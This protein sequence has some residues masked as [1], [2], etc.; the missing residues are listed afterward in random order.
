MRKLLRWLGYGVAA[1]VGLLLVGAAWIW[2]ASSREINRAYA[3]APERLVRPTA[4]QLADAERQARILGCFSCHGEGLAGRMMFSAPGVAEI[5]SP[6]LT[7]VA[8]DASDEQLA[9]A[10]RQG[11]GVDGEP[12]FVMPSAMYSRLSDGEVAALVALIR[13]QPRRGGATPQPWLGP[14]GRFGVATGRLRSAP[15]MLEE[16][17]IREPFDVGPEHAAGRRLAAIA[18]SECH[19]A[20][21]GGGQPS[22][23]I[24]APD[25]ALA[26]AYDPEQ[27]RTLMRTGRAPHG[28]DLG[29]MAEVARNDFAHYTDAEIDRLH[30]YLRARAERVAP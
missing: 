24:Q 19:G 22:P 11:I 1:I 14:L 28:R 25:L 20:D 6:N 23:D 15:A 7:H 17:R 5:W 8:A 18:C 12:L 10:I 21:L 2:F 27:F 4:E 29:L 16:F 9:R 26:G 13:A 30:A 3:A